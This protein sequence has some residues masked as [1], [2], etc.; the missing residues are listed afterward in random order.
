MKKRFSDL[1]DKN[2]EYIGTEHRVWWRK[3][4]ED[5]LDTYDKLTPTKEY[6][7]ED[8]LSRTTRIAKRNLLIAASLLLLLATYGV[9][10]SEAKVFG[11]GLLSKDSYILPGAFAS[12]VIY[13][14]AS[15]LL[16]YA[17]DVNRLFH[18]KVGLAHEPLVYPLYLIQNHL[19][20]IESNARK[21]IPF[22]QDLEENA[23]KYGD[24]VS[25][26]G[27]SYLKVKALTTFSYARFILEVFVWDL[28]VPLIITSAAL[29]LTLNSLFKVLNDVSSKLL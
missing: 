29:S 16:N 28:L 18:A 5:L 27:T 7:V 10:T 3:I 13:Q 15:Y 12:I 22:A 9:S 2:E 25:K 17:R 24:F 11:L 26:V 14:L 4:V 21:G 23:K 20:Q 8:P 19:I 1:L 6:L